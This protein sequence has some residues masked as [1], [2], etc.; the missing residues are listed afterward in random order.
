MLILTSSG[1]TAATGVE[2]KYA[3]GGPMTSPSPSSEEMTAKI[4]GR[5]V[6]QRINQSATRWEGKFRAKNSYTDVI[7]ANCR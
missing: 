3:Q 1:C 5:L 7:S 2:A 4:K 6:F